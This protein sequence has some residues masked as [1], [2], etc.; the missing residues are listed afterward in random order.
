[1][2]NEALKIFFMVNPT[3]LPQAGNRHKFCVL[4]VVTG[5]LPKKSL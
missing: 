1:M 3:R 5:G 4:Y 2:E